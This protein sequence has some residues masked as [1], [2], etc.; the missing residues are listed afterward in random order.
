MH[1]FDYLLRKS[2]KNLCFQVQLKAKL[3]VKIKL[4]NPKKIVK[5]S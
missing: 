5:K 2:V 3:K 4:K 1:E